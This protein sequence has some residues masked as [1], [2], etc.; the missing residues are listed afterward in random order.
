MD[1]NPRQK[2]SHNIVML[3]LLIYFVT[4]SPR[5]FIDL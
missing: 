5:P 4:A 1:V 3:S 2:K